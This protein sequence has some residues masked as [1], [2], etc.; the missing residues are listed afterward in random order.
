MKKQECHDMR[1][2]EGG[3]GGGGKRGGEE[4]EVGIDSVEVEKVVEVV[5]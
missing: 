2:K 4:E 1:R 5:V 3:R